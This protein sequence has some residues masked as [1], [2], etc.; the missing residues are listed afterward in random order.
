[1]VSP[2]RRE[3]IPLK[4]K[5]QRKYHQKKLIAIGGPML[6]IWIGNGPIASIVFRPTK[7]RTK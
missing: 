1:M 5:E 4:V 6:S 7:K 3:I 2:K